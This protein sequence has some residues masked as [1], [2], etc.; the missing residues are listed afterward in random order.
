V[1]GSATLVATSLVD[2]SK[3]LGPGLFVSGIALIS[4]GGLLLRDVNWGRRGEE[5][6]EGSKEVEAKGRPVGVLQA[7][8]ASP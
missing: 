6:K 4:V 2:E 8:I 7:A 5:G 1:G 3:G